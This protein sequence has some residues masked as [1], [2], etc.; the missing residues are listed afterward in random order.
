MSVHRSQ[1]RPWG[2]LVSAPSRSDVLS[3]SDRSELLWGWR[4]RTRE[5]GQGDAGAGSPHRHACSDPDRLPQLQQPQQIENTIFH[6]TCLTLLEIIVIIIPNF[7]QPLTH[8]RL[9]AFEFSTFIGTTQMERLEHRQKPRAQGHTA[10]EWQ[11]WSLNPNTCTLSHR[12][13]MI[14]TELPAS[15]FSICYN[16]LFRLFAKCIW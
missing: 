12:D 15:V 14:A 16:S 8:A 9:P 3:L 1:V 7:F 6:R 2:T 4:K 10:R 11:S 5:T 13:E